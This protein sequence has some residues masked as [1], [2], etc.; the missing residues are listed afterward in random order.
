MAAGSSSTT[1]DDLRLVGFASESRR[2]WP[3]SIELAMLSVMAMA[4][5]WV[6]CKGKRQ[7]TKGQS[8]L[9]DGPMELVV[10]HKKRGMAF[11]PGI[12][13]VTPPY[14]LYYRMR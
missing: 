12:V 8:Q 9:I 1:A 11:L 4:K 14:Y 7:K 6:I 10:T 13:G 2:C 5:V 3:L